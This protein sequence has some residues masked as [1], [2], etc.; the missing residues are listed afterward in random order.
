[1]SDNSTRLA[2]PF[3]QP[4][5]AQ[6]HVTHNEAIRVL[7]AVAQL[8]V[9]SFAATT[10]PALA[11]EG[12]IYALGAG[13]VDAWA[14]H[15]GKI[16]VFDDGYW[17]FLTP[18]TGWLATL[19]GSAEMRVWDGAGWVEPGPGPLDNLDGVG[20]NTSH[21]A[22]NRL[23]VAAPA[24]LFTHDGDDHR[25]KL[26]KAS[27]GD[28]AS[29]LWQDNW[30]GRAEMG[31]AGD[32]DLHLKVS[33]DG[34]AW[35]EAMV[36]DAATGRASFPAGVA[37]VT[38]RLSA[39]RTFYVR[40]D[41]SDAND[42]L[43]DTASGAFRTV[44][45]AVDVAAGLYCGP[46]TVI[47]QIGAGTF[48]EGLFLSVPGNGNLRLRLAG[49]GA[50]TTT[51][52]GSVYGIQVTGPC[53]VTVQNLTI[54]GVT[55]GFWARYGAQVFLRGNVEFAGGSARLLGADNG[56]YVEVL[57]C[58]LHIGVT[59]SAYLLYASGGG[60]IYLGSGVTVAT[61]APVTFTA[62]VF[63]NLTSIAQIIASQV[64]WDETA[65]AISG[66]RFNASSNGVIN[67]AGGGASYLPGTSA[68]VTST[69][70]QYV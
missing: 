1:M 43:A 45:H 49:A 51:I 41:G 57:S 61:T 36:V 64:A 48:D 39:N 8:S 7:D 69:G 52:S 22:T 23:A 16:A 68:G 28:T 3:I 9:I 50:G 31:L 17:Q 62:T 14:G 2:L 54:I 58:N 34:V 44:Q 46:F 12:D 65:G 19:D 10:P 4:A 67:T 66:A 40:A 33:A 13:A 37:G 55:V 21:D 56:A 15:D 70:G 32:D 47:V 26:N 59:A 42:G 27:A 38:E 6:K 24:T 60:H 53:A 63:S 25:L 20:I 11:Q 18:R 30:S 5:Q 35:T 29:L